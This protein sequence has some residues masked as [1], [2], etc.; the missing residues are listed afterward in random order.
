MAMSER[1]Q[2]GQVLRRQSGVTTPVMGTLPTTVGPPPAA[3]SLALALRFD[4]LPTDGC[5]G[6]RGGGGGEWGQS[7]RS[8]AC[9]LKSRPSPEKGPCLGGKR[10]RREGEPPPGGKPPPAVLP[11][12]GADG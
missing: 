5:R 1:C 3:E 9:L 2:G 11:G 12:G 6:G 4:G 10:D 7:R 8:G